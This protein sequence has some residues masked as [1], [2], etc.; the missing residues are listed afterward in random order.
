MA[1][2]VV[3]ELPARTNGLGV[4]N[5]RFVIGIDAASAFSGRLN[6]SICKSNMSHMFSQEAV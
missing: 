5:D 1:I 2:V 4:V 3:C 6:F